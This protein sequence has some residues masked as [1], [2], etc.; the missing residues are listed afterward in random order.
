MIKLVAIDMDGTLLNNNK[1]ISEGNKKALK[2]A[3][4][5]GVKIVLC[6]G[7]P[8]FGALPLYKELDLPRENGYIIVNNG[9]STHETKNFDLVD[10]RELNKDEIFELYNLSREYNVDFTLFDEEHYFFVG[11]EN[12]EPNEK[13]KEDSALVF[14]DVTKISI[15][16]VLNSEK[17]FFESMFLGEKED[18]DVVEKKVNEILK[19]KYNFPRSHIYILEALP[20]D[21]DKGK[22]VRRLAEKLGIKQEEV[23]ALG[24]G[25]NDIEML[26]FAGVSVA[27]K[28]GTELA[29]KYAKYETDTNENDGVAKAIYK[30]VLGEK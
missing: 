10:Y 20:L 23:M 3:I 11:E 19:G 8:L 26:E 9:C 29:K 17:I 27:M 14:V 18:L 15:N 6:T 30:Y 5:R 1:K 12:E 4:N 25:N 13:T 2:D 7:R 21:A 16:E 28:N 22:A 24:D